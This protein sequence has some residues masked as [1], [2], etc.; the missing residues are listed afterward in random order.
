M[1]N[2]AKV[3]TN[4]Q[5]EAEAGDIAG[6]ITFENGDEQAVPTRDVIEYILASTGNTLLNDDVLEITPIGGGLS[7]FDVHMEALSAGSDFD[8]DSGTNIPISLG[9]DVDGLRSDVHYFVLFESD[10]GGGPTKKPLEVELWTCDST[11]LRAVNPDNW[12]V[13]HVELYSDDGTEATSSDELTRVYKDGSEE[14]FT[15]A[16]VGLYPERLVSFHSKT[17]GRSIS[18]GDLLGGMFILRASVGVAAQMRERRNAPMVIR[19]GKRFT[20]GMSA[21]SKRGTFEHESGGAFVMAGDL[22]ISADRVEALSLTVGEKKILA[23]LNHLATK[24]GYGYEPERNCI[25]ATTVD[26]ILEKRGLEPT[27]KNRERARHDLQTIAR[28]AWEFEDPRTHEWLRIPIAGGRAMIRRGGAVEF[29]I[30]ADYMR[31]ILNSRAGQ[32]PMDP[33]LLRTNDKTNPH[34]FTI[35][36]KLATHTYQ[37]YGQTNQNTISVKRLLAYVESIPRPEEVTAQNYTQ[38]IIEPMERDLNALVDCGVLDWWDYSHSKGEPLTDAEQAQRLDSDGNDKPLPYDVAIKANIQWQLAHDYAEHMK[39]VLTAR[40]RKSDEAMEAR[41]KEEERKK[42]MQ[43]RK[44]RR[45]AD[46]LADRELEA[47]DRGESAPSK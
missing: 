24:S 34:A 33:A 21:T 7:R 2:G 10:E 22:M 5:A 13:D 32:L 1:S 44:E 8:F 37:N 14:C 42:R 11:A 31:V 4:I 25:V 39:R 9:S 16:D 45:I 12:L 20:Q 40:K 28:Q 27:R 3:P 41:R 35:G 26:E 30:S 47:A 23:Y 29:S 18:L 17:A 46:K 6:W 38:R 15:L 19:A 43:Q 36:Y